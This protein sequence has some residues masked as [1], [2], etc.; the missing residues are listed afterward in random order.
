MPPPV[1]PKAPRTCYRDFWFF[2]AVPPPVSRKHCERA[3]EISGSCAVVPGRH[4]TWRI[5]NS[6]LGQLTGSRLRSTT[7]GHPLKS[8]ALPA[9]SE[10]SYGVAAGRLT[11]CSVCLCFFGA[12]CTAQ[13][14]PLKPVALPASSEGSYGAAAGRLTR[15]FGVLVRLRRILHNPLPGLASSL[16][17]LES[18][19][20]RLVA[21]PFRGLYPAV[22]AVVHGRT[23]GAGIAESLLRPLSHETLA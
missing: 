7:Q 17:R 20:I 1:H 9:S 14:H 16:F 2:F 22:V 23:V 5:G 13:G 11:G 18:S 4:W 19:N 10:G 12:F 8:V 21:S 3:T 6:R 15:V